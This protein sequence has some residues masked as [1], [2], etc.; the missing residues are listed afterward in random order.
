[1]LWGGSSNR[2]G[3][4]SVGMLKITNITTQST[5]KVKKYKTLVSSFIIFFFPYI[6]I[7]LISNN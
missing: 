4:R 5:F 2:G 3:E 7:Q 1:M 6:N